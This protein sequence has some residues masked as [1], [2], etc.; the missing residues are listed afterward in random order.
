[1]PGSKNS[2]T[3]KNTRNLTAVLKEDPIFQAMMKGELSWGDICMNTNVKKSPNHKPVKFGYSPLEGYV[4]P[5][6]LL[7]KDIW[8]KFPVVLD[9]IASR[10][11]TERYAIKWHQKNLKEYRERAE[12]FD[13]WSDFT[14]WTETRLIHALEAHSHKYTLEVPEAADQIAIIAMV[15]SENAPRHSPTRK[16]A[17][18]NG[19]VL[20][21]LNDIKEHFPVVWHPVD[22]RAGKSTYALELFGKK[23]KELSTVAKRDLT[24]E[25]KADLMRA[26]KAS[27]AWHVLP[28]VGKEVCRLEI[29]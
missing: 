25:I 6:L 7:R 18:Y 12:S 19:P 14:N 5:E 27:K 28:A 3:R 26:L 2:N 16:N 22:G 4:V 11:S 17:S 9:K 21:K 24:I 13:E 10:G 23:V 29:V 8:T 20:R 15:H 1:M